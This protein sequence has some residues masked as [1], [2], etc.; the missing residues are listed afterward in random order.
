MDE[1]QTQIVE[2][3]TKIANLEHELQ[4]AKRALFELEG[5]EEGQKESAVG[6]VVEGSFDGENMIGP[7]GK[8]F[9]VP[10]NYASKSKLVEGDR[11]KLTIG[12]DGSFIYKQIAPAERIKAIGV[13][14]FENNSYFVEVEGRKY[15]VLYASVT[16]HKV[17]PGDKVAIVLSTATSDPKWCALEGVI[18]DLPVVEEGVKKDPA[19]SRESNEI[20]SIENHK[21]TTEPAATESV[22]VRDNAT[23][24]RAEDVTRSSLGIDNLEI[25]GTRSEAA[26]NAVDPNDNQT[27]QSQQQ[28]TSVSTTN[29]RPDAIRELEI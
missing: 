12:A 6:K 23:D 5:T 21:E 14:K 16:Y 3:K 25:K 29:V 8:V 26:P 15:H 13:L 11:L 4:A 1:K 22:P 2:L 20:D 19:G 18:H 9:P 10:A 7:G 17:R 28:P 24:D 27:L